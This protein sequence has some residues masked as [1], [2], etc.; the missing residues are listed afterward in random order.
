M[1]SG[2]YWHFQG[3]WNNAKA[4]V[5]HVYAKK[6]K[7]TTIIESCKIYTHMSLSWKVRKWTWGTQRCK[8]WGQSC[9]SHSRPRRQ[10]WG[11]DH[12]WGSPQVGAL[13]VA[14]SL[15]TET[16]NF[17]LVNYDHLSI[18]I[19]IIIKRLLLT[20]ILR[21]LIKAK[22][23]IINKHLNYSVLTNFNWLL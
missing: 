20:T 1:L 15:K 14:C 16:S 2:Y 23:I 19:F 11:R 5:R 12:R 6:N 4:S 18:I 21:P 13:T 7:N 17:K 10:C 3:N 8:I 22:Q 9:P